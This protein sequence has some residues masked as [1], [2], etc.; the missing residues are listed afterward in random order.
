[1]RGGRVVVA[2]AASGALL[3]GCAGSRPAP[4]PEPVPTS[5]T[6]APGEPT[7]SGGDPVVG[8]ESVNPADFGGFPPREV[9]PP[10]FLGTAGQVP[11]PEALGEYRLL[12]AA[13]WVDEGRSQGSY[14]GPDG[15]QFTFVVHMNFGSYK[16]MMERLTDHRQV[17]NSV[18]GESAAGDTNC[19]AATKDADLTISPDQGSRFGAEELDG[20]ID[21]FLDWYGANL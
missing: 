3:A 21:D 6:P 8:G 2:L 5:A 10:M 14:E 19:A 11:L 9:G 7:G 12:P 4:N 20:L 16:A 1:M 17:G 15:R 18:C 13:A